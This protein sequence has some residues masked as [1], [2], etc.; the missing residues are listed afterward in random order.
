MWVEVDVATLLAALKRI[1]TRRV[2]VQSGPLD[3]TPV[4]GLLPVGDQK[5]EVQVLMGK[6]HSLPSDVTFAKATKPS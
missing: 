6:D 3:G 4:L 5:A 2:A 1:K